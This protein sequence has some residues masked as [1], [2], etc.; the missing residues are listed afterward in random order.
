MPHAATISVFAALS[1]MS[2]GLGAHLGRDS[3]AQLKPVFFTE[4]PETRFF[5][6]Y[7]PF[8]YR[9]GEPDPVR[10]D[11]DWANVFNVSGRPVCVDCPDNFI[12][13]STPQAAADQAARSEDRGPAPLPAEEA[14]LPN[15]TALPNEVARYATYPITSEEARRSPRLA[16]SD[17]LHEPAS[18]GEEVTLP[19]GM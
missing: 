16:H 8:P 1:V 13:P 7:T 5:T 3:V 11:S 9:L 2:A 17:V 6:D 14:V 19:A 15:E 12:E 4:R 18:R 10:A